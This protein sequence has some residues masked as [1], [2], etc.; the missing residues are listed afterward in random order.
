MNIKVIGIDLAKLTFQVCALKNNGKLLFNKKVSRKNLLST[1]RQLDTDAF[2]A[3][4]SCSTCHYWGR[5]FEEMGFTVR[6]VP[7]QHVKPFVKVQKNDANDALAICEAALRPN[8]HFVQVK[9]TRQQ[10]LC[11]LHK[12]RQ[13]TIQQRTA[14]ANKLRAQAGEYGVVF[15]QSVSQLLKQ[16]P[17]ALE[18]A[19]N[20]LTIIARQILRRM[21][22]QLKQLNCEIRQLEKEMVELCGSYESWHAIQSIPGVGPI[23]AS[24]LLGQAGSGQQFKNGRHMS[25]WLGL[26]PKQNSSGGKSK[27]GGITKNGNQ[28]LRCLLIHGA[29]AVLQNRNRRKDAMGDWLQSLVSRRDF[30]KAAVAYANKAARMIWAILSGKEKFRVELAFQSNPI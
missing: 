12:V 24:A 7:P 27:S 26:V 25:A 9:S 13:S 28:D 1:I 14:Q 20:G 17:C 4:E 3:M 30:N 15:N 19:D 23:T 8:I 6:L 18:N 22:E 5:L 10:D 2:I 29:R 21:Y 16:V 11:S